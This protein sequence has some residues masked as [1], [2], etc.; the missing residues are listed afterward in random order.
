[1]S[2]EL[3]RKLRMLKLRLGYR[4]WAELLEK[5]VESTPR[6]IVALGDEDLE[7]IKVG[8]KGFLELSEM[9]SD[10]WRGPPSVLEGFREARGHEDG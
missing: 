3:L 8:V 4:T 5:L 9:V 7:K 2:E 6:E 1:M 10:R